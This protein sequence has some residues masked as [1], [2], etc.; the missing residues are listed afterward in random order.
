MKYIQSLYDNRDIFRFP[1]RDLHV[2]SSLLINTLGITLNYMNA[3]TVPIVEDTMGIKTDD[4]IA[5]MQDI[6]TDDSN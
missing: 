6:K 2:K 1:P 5:F 4:G 3:I